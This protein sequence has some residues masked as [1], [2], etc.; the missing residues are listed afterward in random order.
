ML[1]ANHY[2]RIVQSKVAYY[3]GEMAIVFDWN[4]YVGLPI[5]SPEEIHQY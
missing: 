1:A 5:H 2:Y 4:K 3:F